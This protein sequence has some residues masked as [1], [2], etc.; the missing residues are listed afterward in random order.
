M[1]NKTYGSAS[2]KLRREKGLRQSD[3][4]GLTARQVGRIESGHRATRSALQK[5]AAAHGL[6]VNEYLDDLAQRLTPAH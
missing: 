1:F 3:V 4:P 2:R 6:S 5:L